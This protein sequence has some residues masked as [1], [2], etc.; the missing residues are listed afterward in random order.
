M[1]VNDDCKQNFLE[2]KAKRTYRFI[3]CKIDKKLKQVVV[4]KLGEPSLGYDDFTF[5]LPSEL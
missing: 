4:Q 2:L 3:I 5:S 1:A